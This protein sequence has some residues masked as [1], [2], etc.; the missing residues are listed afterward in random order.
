MRRVAQ[1]IAVLAGWTSRRLGRGGG[2]SLPG[3]VLLRM[4]PRAAEELAVGLTRGSVA[5][6][7]TNGKTTTARLL[8]SVLD[9]E[10]VS[11]VAN[12]AGANLLTGVTAA[13]LDASR[14][15]SGPPS[16]FGLFEVDE[17]A[18]PAVADQVRPRVIVLMNL[19]RDQLDRYG[20][21]ETLLARWRTMIESLDPTTILVL[22]ADDP[23]TAVLGEGRENVVRFGVDA[24]GTDRGALSHAADSTHCPRCDGPLRH[25]VITIGHQG[26]WWCTSCGLRRPEPDVAAV[27]VGLDGVEGLSLTA[28]TPSGPVEVNVA[29]PGLHNA[30][31]VLAA[32]TTA[33]ALDLDLTR[34][35]E[36]LGR[37]QAAFGRAEHVEV[38]GRRLVLLLAK[39]PAGAN[40]NIRTVLT[41]PNA[42]HVLAMLNDRTADGRDVS[43]IWDVDHELLF[44]R[45]AGLV[46]AG[47]RAEELA[48]RFRYGGLDPEKVTLAR[49]P[50]RALDALLAAT[51]P[52]GTAY[53]L[54]T[55]TAMLDLRAE[56]VRR[57]AAKAFWEVS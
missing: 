51:P 36:S 15:R 31:N 28:R 22:N 46:V 38:D 18:L 17:A 29:L 33:V 6:S 16:D 34:A 26:H 44:D 50:A 3:M 53:V 8:R 57:G 24:P 13:L 47:D 21:L 12:S 11:V 54:P 56:L 14:D 39:N 45:L 1:L 30:Y 23:A 7:A 2:T 19:F 40:E 10:G 9:G 43:W 25:D 20:E 52:G 42:V 37:T 49:D 5:I 32:L 4:R 27:R 55:Y 35:A 41:D 48:L